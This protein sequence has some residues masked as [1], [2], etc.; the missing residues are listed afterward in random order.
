[1]TT[2]DI[3]TT[4]FTNEDLTA[5]LAEGFDDVYDSTLVD[6]RERL[7]DTTVSR[8]R[9][10]PNLVATPH[11]AGISTE[12]DVRVGETTPDGV[13]LVLGGATPS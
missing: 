2:P 10:T 9:G 5:S 12:S 3:V 11:I 8:Y 7:L 1:M 4:E 13:R 6:E